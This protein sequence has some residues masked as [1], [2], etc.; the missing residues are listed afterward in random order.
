MYVGGA[1]DAAYRSTNGRLASYGPSADGQLRLLAGDLLAS[2]ALKG[3]KV[4]IASTDLPDQVDVVQRAL[5]ESAEE[6][7]ASTS[8]SYDVMPCQGNIVCT[9]PIPQSVMKLARGQARRR[10]SRF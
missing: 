1:P 6:A 4:A 10:D 7:R 3:K 5:V 8:S 9:Q 2:G